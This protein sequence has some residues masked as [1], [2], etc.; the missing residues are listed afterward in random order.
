M[1]EG[2]PD[3]SEETK[4]VL[5][6]DD[7]PNIRLFMRE[8]LE[9]EGYSILEARNGREGLAILTREHPRVIITDLLMP[10]MDGMDFL[11]A[12]RRE[13]ETKK[14]PVIVLSVKDEFS[15]IRSA[16]EAGA[17][18]YLTKPFDPGYLVAKVNQLSC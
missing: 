5:I 11:R 2:L 7:E 13:P 18:E 6:V 12:T 10:E 14:I 16:F 3:T 17:T 4:S 8:F 15:D 1:A 9:S